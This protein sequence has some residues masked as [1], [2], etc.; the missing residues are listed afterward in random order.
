MKWDYSRA[1][2]TGAYGWHQY[3]S[4]ER[5]PAK[6]AALKRPAPLMKKRKIRFLTLRPKNR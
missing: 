5:W 3:A 2:A 4:D 6:I 1:A